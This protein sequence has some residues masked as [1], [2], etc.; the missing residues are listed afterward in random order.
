MKRSP[1]IRKVLRRRLWVHKKQRVVCTAPTHNPSFQHPDTPPPRARRIFVAPCRVCSPRPCASGARANEVATADK[2]SNP[3]TRGPEYMGL[4]SRGGLTFLSRG[5]FARARAL[6]STKVDTDTSTMQHTSKHYTG[7]HDERYGLRAAPYPPLSGRPDGRPR[8]RGGER[9]GAET[10]TDE[11]ER[12]EV[13]TRTIS[14]DRKRALADSAHRLQ[15]CVMVKRFLRQNGPAPGSAEW[16]PPGCGRNENRV[17]S[18]NLFGSESQTQRGT[19]E[20]GGTVVHTGRAPRAGGC[21]GTL[22][23]NM[24]LKTRERP[25]RPPPNDDRQDERRARDSPLFW[26][27]LASGTHTRLLRPGPRSRW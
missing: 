17:S 9:T 7:D 22:A 23:L 8:Q 19:Q 4:G 16:A 20:L 6:R 18:K 10:A 21:F 26:R 1:S 11:T 25:G 13:A 24:Y 14:E 2:S 15:N 27:G 12:G 3:T 5:L